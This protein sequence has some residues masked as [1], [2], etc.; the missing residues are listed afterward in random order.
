MKVNIYDL[1]LIVYDFDGVMTDNRV[2]V[3]EDGKEAVLC[4]RSDGLAVSYIK[5]SGVAQIILSTE[6]NPVVAARA[7]KL[8]LEVIH[9][10]ENK[11]RTLADF[12]ERCR[13]ALAKVL[14]IGNDRNDFDVMRTVGF[15]FC[16]LNASADIR[17]IS[18]GVIQRNGGDG[19]IRFLYEH[20]LDFNKGE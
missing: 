5:R 1:D 9:G 2:F 10:V 8:G 15:P 7:K 14:Y 4:N 3:F 20:I 6:K 17:E 11:K 19:V 16:P 13:Y 12:C 18:K